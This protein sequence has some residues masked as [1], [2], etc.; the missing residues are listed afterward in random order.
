MTR[1]L[2]ILHLAHS[3]IRA[4]HDRRARG[5]LERLAAAALE[6]LLNA[7]DANDAD[8]GR[9]VRRVAD[10][11]LIIADAIGLDAAGS[12][13]VERVALFHDIGKIHEALFDIVHDGNKL[14]PADRRAVATHPARGAHVLAPLKAFFPELPAGVLSHH[15]RWDGTGY[16]RGL[17]GRRIPLEARIVA[18]ADTFDAVSHTRPY[19]RGLGTAAA[20][21]IIEE[22]R[23]TQF[24][25]ELVDLVMLQPITARML[26]HMRKV[27]TSRRS[28]DGAGG[29]R[30]HEPT[31]D[32][33]FRWRS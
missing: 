11:A 9:H 32:V 25:P 29:T 15:E 22:G 19:H 31:P 28:D 30:M 1:R 17:R 2:P 18:I 4:P 12:R 23:G 27:H 33:S 6:T 16:P 21:R 5:S 13:A 3:R 8:T 20:M 14:T 10:F 26:T 24:D 7:I